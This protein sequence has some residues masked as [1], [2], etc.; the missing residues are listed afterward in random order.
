MDGGHVRVGR[1]LDDPVV[2][3]VSACV[4]RGDMSTIVETQRRGSELDSGMETGA[5]GGRSGRRSGDVPG[6]AGLE[7][8]PYR[9]WGEQVAVGNVT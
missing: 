1:A 8:I 6:T 7:L 5:V 9:Q 3:P 4:S 2:E